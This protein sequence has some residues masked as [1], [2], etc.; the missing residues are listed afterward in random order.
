MNLMGNL[1]PM[2]QNSQA[3][4]QLYTSQPNIMQLQQPGMISGQ[5]LTNQQMAA[6]QQYMN[7]VQGQSQLQVNNQMG[8]QIKSNQFVM[9]QN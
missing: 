9:N 8:G 4:D 5:Q 6:H 7:A 3:K 2:G 1:G